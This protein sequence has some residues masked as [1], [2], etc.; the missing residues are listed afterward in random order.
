MSYPA[1]LIGPVAA[2]LLIILMLFMRSRTLNIT[3]A[4]AI[5]SLF[6]VILFFTNLFRSPYNLI[7]FERITSEVSAIFL[8]L[9]ALSRLKRLPYY[10][11]AIL[12]PVLLLYALFDTCGSQILFSDDHATFLYRL[13]MLKE[14]F[15]Y[16][17][18]YNP[19]WNAGIDER[20]FFATGVLN[21]FF[22]TAPF[23]YSLDLWQ[24]YTLIP[25]LILFV[26]VPGASYLGTRLTSGSRQAAA[27][28]TMLA[29][30]CSLG[31]YHWSLNYGPLGFLTTAA[32]T[33][34]LTALAA[35]ILS[36]QHS[37]Q[38]WEAFATIAVGT[39][40]LL[41][42]PGGI[43]F[44]PALLIGIFKCRS[45]LKQRYI[46]LILTGL[47]IIN[48][49]W[50][51][52]FW[53][54]SNVSSFLEKTEDIRK[55]QVVTDNDARAVNPEL[56]D[57]K[58]IPVIERLQNHLALSSKLLNRNLQS[59]NPIILLLAIPA[60]FFFPAPYRILYASMALWLLALGSIIAPLKAQLEFDRMLIVLCLFLSVPIGHAIACF[61]EENRKRLTGRIISSF[62][63]AFII[64][65]LVS[66]AGILRKRTAINYS[67]AT[68]LVHSLANAL[69][70]FNQDGRVLFT[71]FVLHELEGG[72]LAP[73]TTLT[74]TPLIASSQV[75]NHWKYRDVIPSEFL[76]QGPEKIEAFYDLLNV[77]GLVTTDRTWRG[78]LESLPD[79]YTRVWR[80]RNFYIFKRN[81]H[82]NSYFLSGRGA[83]LEQ[84]SHSVTV[85]LDTPDATIKFK[86]FPFLKA[87]SCTIS[88]APVAEEITFITLNNCPINEPIV[89][90]SKPAYVRINS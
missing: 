83:V 7:S 84:N 65:G 14:N 17:P 89:I 31:W 53:S 44:L 33:P 76:G 15:P 10:V 67:T 82:T 41:W 63:F 78:Y 62:L 39:L 37:L 66:T 29:L 6:L 9:V 54:A 77:T 85:T 55:V 42:S 70:S 59:A 23:I 28:S 79:L 86:Y 19:L 60:L 40:V 34:L 24:Y 38:L 12:A 87:S 22:L 81:N 90:E 5:S 43:V 21:I 80:E 4:L 73:L 69:D 18:F 1:G 72:H 61:I 25:A 26:I 88:P 64:I 56:L 35:R 45:L 27:I 68:P 20:Y 52:V 50:V 48:V 58:D 3:S 32:L 2:L 46:K 8:L 74:N 47:F 71:G 51:L 30:S 49:P 13:I 75:H 57:Q 11:V 36:G 16:I